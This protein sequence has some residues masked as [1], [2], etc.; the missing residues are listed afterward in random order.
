MMFAKCAITLFAGIV[1]WPLASAAQFLKS[2]APIVI[3]ADSGSRNERTGVTEYIGNVNIAQGDLSIAADR[4]TILYKDNQVAMIRCEGDPAIFRRHVNADN[5]HLVGMAQSID[6][7][8]LQQT[9]DLT[10]NASLSRNGTNL[11]GDTIHY[12]LKNEIWRA[13]GN[14]TADQ[15]RIQLVI[16]P[17]SS[18]DSET[19][20]ERD[21]TD[22]Q[23]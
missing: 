4:V 1:I 8:L 5:D 16:P 3:D 17:S 18:I 23:P 12:D 2:Q 10:S 15:K 6:Y 7:S 22:T 20:V 11:K 9:I 21:A 19:P 14:D 13:R